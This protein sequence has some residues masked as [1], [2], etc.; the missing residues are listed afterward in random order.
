MQVFALTDRQ[1]PVSCF[2]DWATA[3]NSF[4]EAAFGCWERGSS[5]QGESKFQPLSQPCYYSLFDSPV[6]L[7][8]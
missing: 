5:V 2:C 8:F 7:V 4:R 3:R 6:A 1:Q